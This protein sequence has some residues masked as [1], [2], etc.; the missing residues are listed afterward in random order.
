[1]LHSGCETVNPHLR[2]HTQLWRTLGAMDDVMF[3][4]VPDTS[5][6]GT[7]SHFPIPADSSSPESILPKRNTSFLWDK[8]VQDNTD[9]ESSFDPDAFFHQHRHLLG[10]SDHSTELEKSLYDR[11]KGIAGTYSSLESKS[12]SGFTSA[13][14]THLYAGMTTPY[15]ELTYEETL[16]EVKVDRLKARTPSMLG[17]KAESSIPPTSEEEAALQVFL[18]NRQLKAQAEGRGG[19]PPSVKHEPSKV[20]SEIEALKKAKEERN[21]SKRNTTSFGRRGSILATSSGAE[22]PR[23]KPRSESFRHG[24]SGHHHHRHDTTTDAS[25][26]DRL[27]E[28]LI[29]SY[30]EERIKAVERQIR[31]EVAEEANLVKKHAR[32]SPKVPFPD[33]T[34][35][36]PPPASAE[37]SSS[38]EYI[39]REIA[40][41][42]AAK[43][44][45]PGAQAAQGSGAPHS[46]DASPSRSPP[47]KGPLSEAASP[48]Q[49]R[50]RPSGAHQLSKVQRYKSVSPR[51]TPPRTR[52]API[53]SNASTYRSHKEPKR[54]PIA[55][56][57]SLPKTSGS[58]QSSGDAAD[59]KRR[60]RRSTGSRSSLTSLLRAHE[61][62]S[63]DTELDNS[64]RSRRPGGSGKKASS[65]FSTA[66]AASLEGGAAGEASQRNLA[67][68]TYALPSILVTDQAIAVARAVGAASV[69]QEPAPFSLPP[70]DLE[71]R[72]ERQ[73]EAIYSTPPPAPPKDSATKA[74]SRESSASPSRRQPPPRPPAPAAPRP[75][76]RPPPPT[77]HQYE[78]PPQSKREGQPPEA[79]AR[80]LVPPPVPRRPK[81]AAPQPPL[82]GRSP[83]RPMDTAQGE[84]TSLEAARNRA[85]TDASPTRGEYGI[86]QAKERHSSYMLP[87]GAPLAGDNRSKQ[88]SL[89]TH[90]AGLESIP[91]F[92]VRAEASPSRGESTPTY[93]TVSETATSPVVPEE[94][95]APPE[96]RTHE[97]AP[98]AAHA[99]EAGPEATAG[100]ADSN[101]SAIEAAK[102]SPDQLGSDDDEGGTSGRPSRD[103]ERR[104]PAAS[105]PG[106]PQH[107]SPARQSLG[108]A[109]A[110]SQPHEDRSQADY[111][112]MDHVTAYPD[113]P[114]RDSLDGHLPGSSHGTG[115]PPPPP[116]PPA[117]SGVSN[118]P[119]GSGFTKGPNAKNK[120]HKKLKN[121]ADEGPP[122]G[123]DAADKDKKK[124]NHEKS[125]KDKD[126][127]TGGGYRPKTEP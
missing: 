90:Q 101:P 50:H 60:K 93:Q 82:S 37:D 19:A 42:L 104:S 35:A 94:E 4:P 99:A 124:D 81:K 84:K 119:S 11:R 100:T 64:T 65:A 16:F 66:R 12:H 73:L 28:T 58:L 15:D 67:L 87:Q 2:A 63:S 98:D 46:K 95:A 91:S 39:L 78:P 125:G 55:Q 106:S 126:M 77:F 3:P 26:D 115:N 61:T 70:A 45:L 1:M 32:P 69:P 103:A 74:T 85:S 86:I 110:T 96:G 48:R 62:S 9:F 34:S 51:S 30:I 53:H 59:A 97:N 116:A 52:K 75:P 123:G 49:L 29:K 27:S 108:Q 5:L 114:E 33:M 57:S 127:E 40:A 72:Q 24:R 6:K 31:Q 23:A 18:K 89:P 68:D 107:Q 80:S 105:R 79:A 92:Q 13:H 117:A 22:R 25:L 17:G 102:A 47:R 121:E 118:K 43:G 71:G 76:P 112:V 41:V 122:S 21:Y 14:D 10:E 20:K 36:R 113:H 7:N 8:T 109:S 83:T 56:D 111:F 38:K 88:E 44:Y 120:K 54:E